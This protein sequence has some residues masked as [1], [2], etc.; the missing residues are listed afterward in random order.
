MQEVQFS[1]NAF[2]LAS[3]SQPLDA[4]T[5]A[6]SAQ[7]RRCQVALVLTHHHT[8][9]AP[10]HIAPTLHQPLPQ[11]IKALV[12]AC[13]SASAP[14]PAP[15]AKPPAPAPAAPPPA[16]EAADVVS[17]LDQLRAPA[18]PAPPA[19]PP[20]DEITTQESQEAELARLVAKKELLELATQ[21]KWLYLQKHHETVAKDP[22]RATHK[23]NWEA[24]PLMH[25]PRIIAAISTTPAAPGG[26]GPGAKQPDGACRRPQSLQRFKRVVQQS[27]MAMQLLERVNDM[28]EKGKAG[29]PGAPAGNGGGGNGGAAGG[30]AAGGGGG[31]AAP[32]AEA[33]RAQAS[34]AAA[35][36]LQQQQLQQQQAAQQQQQAQQQAAYVQAYQMGLQAA[37][38]GQQP[39]MYAYAWAPGAPGAPAGS[40]A[41]SL[42]A[43][44]PGAVVYP[45]Q[46]PHMAVAMVQKRIG[47]KIVQ[48][49][50]YVQ[51]PPGA[52]YAY[53]PWPNAAYAAA[54]PG[55]A[56]QQPPGALP[57]SGSLGRAPP[58][59]PPQ[60]SSIK[61][62]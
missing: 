15:E 52:Q 41:G 11:V 40:P 25:I 16:A 35:A 22:L 53:A 42:S 47:N 26:D 9:P 34:A 18:T 6:A 37:Q 13:G 24:V 10:I 62:R 54:A 60:Q 2:V 28:L 27:N 31:A 33:A 51:A 12:D 23:A 48:V 5:P 38:P 3:K 43:L 50:T 58:P 19:P 46:Q 56:P 45:G 4:T 57:Q 17:E 49:P 21:D 7:V 39:Y 55:M 14:A 8:S 36:A 59:A 61:R 32:D 44:P 29:G 30:G 20:A 1:G